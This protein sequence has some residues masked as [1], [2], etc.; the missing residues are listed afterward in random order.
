MQ[1]PPLQT[2]SELLRK[3]LSPAPFVCIIV[4]RIIIR[5][6]RPNLLHKGA[7]MPRRK[8]QFDAKPIPCTEN[9]DAPALP[10]AQSPLGD[11]LG[12]LS[13]RQKEACQSLNQAMGTAS[14]EQLD[15]LLWDA[16]EAFQDY[17]FLTA[18]KLEFSYVLKGYEMFV[19]RKDKSITKAT[20]LLSFHNALSAQASN[21]RVSGPKKLGTFGASYLYPIFLFFGIIT[22]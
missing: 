5:K 12:S 17:P 21:G 7:A 8:N 22:P 13:P 15:S 14:A 16:L 10:K 2:F 6:Y 9:Q 18:K 20:V 1:N 11:S 4:S 19:S 3:V